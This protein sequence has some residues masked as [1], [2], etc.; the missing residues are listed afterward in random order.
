[1]S[2]PLRGLLVGGKEA[3]KLEEEANLRFSPVAER[4]ILEAANAFAKEG[5][6]IPLRHA[7]RDILKVI[8]G[9]EP[10]V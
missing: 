5:G 7:I 10:T 8:R 3:D 6:I 4:K 9:N 2:N 1:M